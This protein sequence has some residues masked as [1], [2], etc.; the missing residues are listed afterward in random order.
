ML[1]RRFAVP[2]TRQRA[3]ATLD[4]TA[5][6]LIPVASI[7]GQCARPFF[8]GEDG[9]VERSLAS[10]EAKGATAIEAMIRSQAPPAVGTNQWD[11]VIRF[12]AVQHGRTPSAVNV[13][14]Q[15][16]VA[17]ID[18]ARK[19]A[20]SVADDDAISDIA[21][22]LARAHRPAENLQ[23]SAALAP[24]LC[25]LDDLLLINDTGFGF[26]ISDVGVLVHNQ[27]AAGVKGMGVDGLACRGLIILL[28]IS[29]RHL[30][31]KYDASVYHVHGASNGAVRVRDESQVKSFNCIS[32]VFAERNIYFDGDARTK[33]GLE[34]LATNAVRAPL[35]SM[36][37][38]ERLT[39][40]S[41]MREVIHVYSERPK[42]LLALEWLRV[43]PSMAKL[44]LQAR[45]NQFRPDALAASRAIRGELD[46]PDQ[47]LRSAVFRRVRDG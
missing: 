12:I 2:G 40:Q 22:S 25:D 21:R 35:S 17:T 14:N 18:E 24:L 43:K 16:L 26:A 28:P 32:I 34:K 15:R 31:M 7:G 30:L 29:P 1:L 36:V 38:A 8:Y 42:I 6:R 41:G 4:L 47:T 46:A 9:V 3:V 23:M 44:S 27:W 39:D 11:D 45:V 37:R 13:S 19:F 5:R 33:A 20:R 10:L